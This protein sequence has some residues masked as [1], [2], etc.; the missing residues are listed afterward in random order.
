MAVYNMY[1]EDDQETMASMT[2]VHCM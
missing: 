2:T 1:D